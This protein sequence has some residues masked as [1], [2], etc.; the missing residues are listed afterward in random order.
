MRVRRTGVVLAAALLA[1]V[2]AAGP[3]AAQPAAPGGC[4]ASWRTLD[5]PAAPLR[6]GEFTG[7]GALS[8]RDV[9]IAG[10]TF[11]GRDI[12]PWQTRW[13]GR[14]VAEGNTVATLPDVETWQPI[15]DYA[16][17]DEG[18]A[19]NSA[20]D[21]QNAEHWHDGRWTMLPTAVPQDPEHSSLMLQSI[22]SVGTDDAWAVGGTYEAG[23][24]VLGN[25]SSL[26]ALIEHWDGS[27]WRIV[28]NPVADEPDA[29]L[30]SVDARSATDV[31]A[32]GLRITDGDYRALIEHYDGAGWSVVTPPADNGRSGMRAVDVA[33]D[34]TVVAVGSQL[35][36]GTETDA[37][38]LVDVFDGTSWHR[39]DLP[40]FGNGRL[41]AVY[42]AGAGSIWA[43]FTVPDG[44]HTFVRWDGTSWTTLEAPGPRGVGL[45]YYLAAI[46]GT[47][48]ND[49]W[50]VGQVLNVPTMVQTPYVAHL[51]CGGK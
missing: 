27:S 42:T 23:P 3:A 40:D 45:G 36:P 9:R 6:N 29:V 19:L 34:G 21:W 15:V 31:W 11:Y 18:W 30:R 17:A 35:M 46:D 39:A 8:A 25:T 47:G 20:T 22:S 32:V 48:P 12:R 2:G 50:A 41:D 44:T 33:P 10:F 16:S 43:L 28:P 26:G 38:A 51:S 1:S 4:A 37:V 24:G 5:A 7:V 14:Q 13:D 49:V